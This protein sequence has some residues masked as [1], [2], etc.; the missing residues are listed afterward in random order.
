MSAL[1]LQWTKLYLPFKCVTQVASVSNK[2]FLGLIAAGNNIYFADSIYKYN[3]CTKTWTKIIE[4]N[5]NANELPPFGAKFAIDD[6]NQMAY[7]HT[8]F[9]ELMEY[10]LTSNLSTGKYE[11]VD[12]LDEYHIYRIIHA[13]NTVHIFLE[14]DKHYIFDKQTKKS[15]HISTRHNICIGSSSVFVKSR[16]SI[17]TTTQQCISTIHL[18]NSDKH[19]MVSEFSVINHKWNNFNKN[20]PFDSAIVITKNE[21]YL[22][23]CGGYVNAYGYTDLIL[24]YDICGNNFSESV[25]KCPNKQMFVAALT[26]ND[27]KDELL[28]F[29]FINDCFTLSEL[30]DVPPLPP[31]LIRFISNYV[32]NETIHLISKSNEKKSVHWLINVDKIIQS[33]K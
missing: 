17:I 11:L 14:G 27:E 29:G 33:L 2:E 15:Q 20:A 22:I 12:T 10:D 5:T 4:P 30:S 9:E 31:Y 7:I 13:G 32:C 1:E 23:L 26:R 8:S 24:V 19:Q 18:Q 28:A 3:S 6:Q 25:V 16:Q 21:Q